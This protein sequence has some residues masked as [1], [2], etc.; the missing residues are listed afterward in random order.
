MV[1]CS[2]KATVYIA[3]NTHFCLGL[4]SCQC[5]IITH[6]QPSLA[7]EQKWSLC[8][9]FLFLS[10]WLFQ[11]KDPNS[12]VFTMKCT[13]CFFLVYM[14]CPS[15]PL[16]S[17]QSICKASG[18]SAFY[19]RCAAAWPCNAQLCQLLFVGIYVVVPWEDSLHPLGS[20]S[21]LIACLRFKKG[22]V[23]FLAFWHTS[24]FFLSKVQEAIQDGEGLPAILWSLD[25]G[26][27]VA[28]LV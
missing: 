16:H 20:S 6:I 17:Q 25:Y 8:E 23:S 19:A 5:V 4:F 28:E 1:T 27:R 2:P 11:C 3:T 24:F 12:N 18:E 13:V 21:F 15:K 10:L 7:P 14:A 26:V 22:I 9:P